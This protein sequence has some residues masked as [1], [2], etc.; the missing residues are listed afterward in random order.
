M[1][2]DTEAVKRYE[3]WFES[4]PGAFAYAQERKLLAR[5]MACWPRRGQELLEIGCGPGIF[6][7]SFWEDGFDVSGLDSSPEMLAAARE[8]LGNR[9]EFHLGHADTLPFRD[10]EFDFVVLLTLL[11]FM[12][13]PL[14][15]L[16]EAK[17]TARKSV[18]VAFLNK[19]SFYYLS[20]GSRFRKSDSA[21]RRAYWFTPVS[22]YALLST[23]FGRKPMTFRSVLPGPY[24]T[25]RQRFPWSFLNSFVYPHCVG[26]YCAVRVDLVNE[27]PLTPLLSRTADPAPSI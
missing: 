18:L 4:G 23:V 26:C 11:E 24:M 16:T 12:E 10:K 27:K 13:D 7:S 2:W 14:P 8:R 5:L 25:W 19:W 6:L 17:R 20:H 15:V 22:M 1:A 21:L 9:A 3:A